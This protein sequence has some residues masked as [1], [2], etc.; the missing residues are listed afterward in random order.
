MKLLEVEGYVP[1]CLIAGDATVRHH[2]SNTL[3]VCVTWLIAALRDYS[4]L[5][6]NSY[7]LVQALFKYS[8]CV[9]TFLLTYLLNQCLPCQSSDIADSLSCS[10]FIF[11]STCIFM[12]SSGFA[13]ISSQILSGLS[14]RFFV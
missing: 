7:L 4:Y 2:C 14:F 13:I 1:Q 6:T 5:W 11:A 8:S 10:A 12:K 3:I 9:Y